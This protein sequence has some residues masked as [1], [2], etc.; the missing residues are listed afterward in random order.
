MTKSA[1]EEYASRYLR[2]GDEDAFHSLIESGDES[3]E[4]LASRLSINTSKEVAE[5][6]QEIRTERV[7]LFLQEQLKAADTESCWRIFAEALAY[8]ANPG[9]EFYE[10]EKKRLESLGRYNEAKYCESFF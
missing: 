8:Q 3:L 4:V 2:T 7:T 1:L 10:V 5:I 9:K 6:L